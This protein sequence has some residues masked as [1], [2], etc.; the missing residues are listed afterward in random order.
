MLKLPCDCFPDYY[1]NGGTNGGGG[2]SG[3]PSGGPPVPVQGAAQG[4]YGSYYQNNGAYSALPAAK[5]PKKKP[6]MHRGGKS[7]FLQGPP[8]VPA[9]TYPS[10]SPSGQGPYSQY[11][12]Y[13]KKS[14]AQ[15]QGGAA[16]YS[17]A[18]PSQVTGGAGASQDYNYDG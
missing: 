6:P 2:A 7:P 16:G 1:N 3:S 18:Y 9:P 12:G 14:F 15:N 10:G 17:T 4:S 5:A 13:G 11:Q 8:G